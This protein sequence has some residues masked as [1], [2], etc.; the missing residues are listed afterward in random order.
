MIPSHKKTKRI[1]S[2]ANKFDDTNVQFQWTMTTKP[3]WTC[4]TITIVLSLS[5]IEMKIES[6]TKQRINAACFPT[7]N[8]SVK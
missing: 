4:P 3:R 1:K 7:A 6:K 8:G 2:K 5:P